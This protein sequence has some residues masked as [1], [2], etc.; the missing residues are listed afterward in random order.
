[1][2]HP[3]AG[4][5][6]PSLV[7]LGIL[8]LPDL[9]R[10]LPEDEAP[11]A[12][13]DP[14]QAL[15]TGDYE[16]AA[17]GFQA[18][19]ERDPEKIEAARGWA[20]ALAATGEYRKALE[21]LEKSPR[22]EKA[23]ALLVFAG[24]IQLL[25]GR[26][27]QAEQS[28]RAA[29]EL[30]P[31]HIESLNRLG[32][33]L[34]RTGRREEARASWNELV[35]VYE[36]LSDDDAERLPAEA[37]VEMGL[38]LVGLNRYAEANDVMFD[39]AQEKDPKCAE[40]LLEWGRVF[41]EKHQY[42]ECKKIILE[43]LDQNRR[44]ADALVL[45]AEYLLT[46]F[47][48]G[49]TRYELAEREIEKALEINP[50]L[51]RAYVARGSL[52]LTDGNLPRAQADF[53]KALSI[54]PA[55]LR[56]R[57]LL[58]A[59]HYLSSNE[60]AF[61]A[62]EKKALEINP[63]AAEF[64]HTIAQAIETRFRYADAVKM[65]SRAVELDPDYWPAFSTLGI[66]CLRTGDEERGREFV[67]KSW[68]HDQFSPWILNTRKLHRHIDRN[69]RELRTERFIFS[70][71]AEDFEV[72]STHLVPLLE[73]A[74][75]TLSAHYGVELEPPIRI[76]VFSSHQW[77]SARIVGLGGFPASGACF[78]N[79]VALTT[80]KALPQHWGA[81][82]WHEF[83]HVIALHLTKHRV[84]RWLTEGLSV[85]EEGRDHPKWARLFEREIADAFGS[86]RLLPLGELDFGFSKPK[87]P[88]QVLIS[89]FQGCLIV[90]YIQGRWGW[91][92]VLE[93]L[94]GYRDNKATPQIFREAF[95]MSLE[96]FDRG[97]FAY[98]ADWVAKTG[99]EPEPGKEV[100]ARLEI[101]LSERP[102]DVKL[103]CDLAWAYLVNGNDIDAPLTAAK[104]LKL[105]P[106]SGDAHAIIG[107]SQLAER[108]TRQAKEALEKA[109]EKGSRF[110]FHGHWRLGQIAQRER[111]K[112]A[113]I[114]H[115]EAA[116][117]ASPRA[118][119]AQGHPPGRNLYYQLADLY[120]ETG[121]EA[122]ALRVLDEL[123]SFTVEDGA[124]R[125]RL[126]KHYLR[127]EGEE[128]AR[129]A[130]ELLDELI[131]IDP[132]DRSLHENLAR[133]AA[134]I[135]AH[136]ITIR[137]YNYLLIKYPD[138]N[139]RTAHLALAKAYLALEKREEARRSAE[140][141]LAIDPENGEAKEVLKALEAEK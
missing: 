140:K 15:R 26:L 118:G 100:V 131:Y 105:D 9:S 69:H 20:E 86:G 120:N 121:R 104:A 99:Y 46:D 126:L 44:F 139:P 136:E 54:N 90:K 80:P 56:G 108:K 13:V 63:R 119:A 141:V 115:F 33:V 16:G 66:N 24:R 114:R 64:Y 123:R 30:E 74:Y 11:A 2:H 5:R 60:E 97:F 47:Q 106:E 36:D 18:E 98:L 42:P 23:P 130:F 72:L 7:L 68:K 70:F 19:L 27:A 101:E 76:E 67:D 82:A 14:R 129:K 71:P 124:S 55:D 61:A 135:G 57:G 95:G 102:D 1:M 41:L 112:E 21:V 127:Q 48:V 3:T 89:Y 132:F 93:I 12:L 38:A 29:L 32:E 133:V 28:F 85:F 17:A 122:D 73:K 10:A 88:M 103:L 22:F 25:T 81:V 52:W 109:L 40:L 87:Y 43:A 39:Q 4:F 45:K 35:Q 83:A 94:H 96:D 91:D 84:P 49:T 92:K 110:R 111:D 107:F 116:K 50:N 6:L 75:D 137:E 65:A 125:M 78:G 134:R 113:A 128:A 62:E 37:F 79:V 34:H 53:E 8:A 77:F 138:T 117:Q 51:A 31:R 59:C 58:A